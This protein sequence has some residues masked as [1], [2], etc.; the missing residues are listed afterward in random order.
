MEMNAQ[1]IRHIIEES[2]IPHAENCLEDARSQL[3]GDHAGVIEAI[4]EVEAAI[5]QEYLE[6]TRYKVT[7]KEGN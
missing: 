2:G 1:V 6:L 5:L 4:A 3:G 7:M